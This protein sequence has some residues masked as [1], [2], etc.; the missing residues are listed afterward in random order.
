MKAMSVG[1]FDGKIGNAHALC[2]GV[3]RNH[4]FVISDPK[5]P[6]PYIKG[7]N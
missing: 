5:L 4:I 3:I 7:K 2:H 6:I 1:H